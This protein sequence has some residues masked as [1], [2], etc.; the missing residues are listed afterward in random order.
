MSK[1]DVIDLKIELA[2]IKA[3]LALLT[4]QKDKIMNV[5]EV[6]EYMGCSEATIRRMAHRK[7]LINYGGPNK[8]MRFKYADLIV[9]KGSIRPLSPLSLLN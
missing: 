8:P 5:K 2:E 4:G 3:M 7:D 6:A 1:D 9:Q